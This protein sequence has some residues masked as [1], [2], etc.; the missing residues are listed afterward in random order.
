MSIVDTLRLF[1]APALYFTMEQLIQ[2]FALIK[3]ENRKTETYISALQP[4]QLLYAIEKS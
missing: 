3:G 2:C 1:R 4:V